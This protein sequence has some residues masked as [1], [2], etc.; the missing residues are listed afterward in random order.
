MNLVLELRPPE[1][2]FYGS[3]QERLETV[4]RLRRP[5]EVHALCEQAHALGV[6]TILAVLDDTI[7]EALIAFQRWREVEVWAVLP[8]MFAFIRD[9][10][11]LGMVGAARARFTRLGPAAMVRTGLGAVSR[12]GAIRRRDFATGTTLVA[13]MEL[14]A[15]RGLRVTRLFLHPQVTEVALAGGV[16]AA[17]TALADRAERLGIEAGIVT[18]NPLR[19]AAV[20]GRELGRFAAVVAP[21]NPKGYKMFPDREAC[22]QLYRREPGRFI[23]AEVSA[24]DAVAP[25]PALAH[26]RALGLA[27]AVLDPRF[28]ERAFRAGT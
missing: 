10:T 21:C 2:R 18:H 15:L 16:S 6:R 25:G 17:F 26:V 28:V 9:L 5:D 14:A 3:W 8:N 11:D 4:A 20:L 27:G 1:S 13:E 24:G 19:A 22:E 12:L 23:A 7:R